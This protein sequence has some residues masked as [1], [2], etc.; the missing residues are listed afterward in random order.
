MSKKFMLTTVAVMVATHLLAQQKDTATQILEPLIVTANRYEQKQSTTGKVITVI[1]KATLEKNAGKN[2]GQLLT[3]QAGIVVAGAYNA[4]GS[5]QTI[6]TRGAN[7]GRTLI[8]I[9]GIP[10]TDP[11]NITNDF[12]INLFSLNDIEQIEVCRGAQSTLY[13][14]DA[15]AGVINIIT[16]KNN[17][18]KPV[19][20][21][22]T[23][24]YGSLNT[25]RSST[26]LFGKVGKLQYNVR[27]A[28]IGTNGFTSAY[29]STAA[30]GFDDDGYNGNVISGTLQYAATKQLHIRSFIQSSNYIADI[31]AGAF[32]DEKDF[33]IRN[34]M[35]NA[36]SGFTF[37]ND[38][39][40]LTG[41]FQYTRIQRNYTN[42]S[43]DRPGFTKYMTNDYNGDSKF[44]ELY[45]A[46]QLGSG[47]TLVQG[48]DFRYNNMN[49]QYRSLSSFGPFNTDFKDTSLSQTSVYASLNYASKNQKLFVEIG[50]RLNVHSRYGNNNTYTFNPSYA[51]H[52]YWRVFGS[53]ST[54]F[55][56]PSIFQLYDGF[57]GNRNLAAEESTNYELGVAYR[58]QNTSIR[59]VYF[60]RIIDNGIDY[61]Y[62]SNKY[63]N[64]IT[65]KVQGVEVEANI[66]LTGKWSINANY[67]YL[68]AKETTQNRASLRDTIQYSYLLR[69]PKHSV[70]ASINYTPISTLQFSVEVRY[71]SSRFDVGG[72]RR[73][74]VALSDYTLFSAYA[75]YTINEHVKVFADVQNMFGQKF[76]D[77]RGFAAM[78]RL[79]QI[80]ITA[81][82]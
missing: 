10:V 73:A 70:N 53:V 57:S 68:D 3:E 12:D 54:G 15:I 74:D 19:N 58:K 20:V 72:F 80:G 78:P 75:S 48:G 81:N 76:F 36:G 40:T 33:I 21:K 28:H 69:R 52:K 14:S 71:V 77:I 23:L 50:G 82:W 27:Y 37:K 35:L 47:F 44:A 30:K 67:T 66:A 4:P 55:K 18:R 64:F 29:D 6:F 42:D 79:A 1:D 2:L 5:V 61:N 24:S 11:S 65:Q 39:I 22:T 34:R 46:I 56:S 43:I 32:N 59:T 63:F 38:M 31:D 45:A 41:N 62:I 17:V 16:T 26:Q 13:G 7:A 8:L 49:N 51:F 60:N 25:L 9:D